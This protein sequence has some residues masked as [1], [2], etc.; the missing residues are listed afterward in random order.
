[1]R[2]TILVDNRDTWI[3]PYVHELI[4]ILKK[5]HEVDFVRRHEDI[6]KGDLA[7]FLSCVNV[8]PKETLSLSKHNLVI[9]ES[10]LPK[11]KGW[12]PLA[13][14]IVE[15]KNNIPITLFEAA[16]KVDS[17]CI[18]FQDMMQFE[19]HELLDELREQQG[20][21]T[22][23]FVLKFVNVYPNI[24]GREQD[25]QETFYRR[26]ERKDD[27]IDVNKTITQVFN[28][29][30]VAN[31]EEYPL[32][33]KYKGYKYILKIYKVEESQDLYSSKCE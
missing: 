3:L 5:N 21:K 2:I 18:Y 33:L 30:R 1:M 23:D 22:I 8:V 15:G 12:S 7:F 6:K 14:Q 24:E 16:E 29:F 10:A 31:N 28:N 17:G 27:E 13:W 26:R 19:G 25:G 20:R 4:E 9:H 32:F 11:G